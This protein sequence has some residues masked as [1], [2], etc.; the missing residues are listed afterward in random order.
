MPSFVFVV[1][2]ALIPVIPPF[3]IVILSVVECNSSFAKCGTH[4]CSCETTVRPSAEASQPLTVH[5]YEGRNSP[6]AIS[7][8]A[9]S[10]VT[11][12]AVTISLL[13]CSSVNPAP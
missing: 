13:N 2:I 8:F 4:L 1:T 12:F 5:I 10:F 3:G 7:S 11:V 9:L 6:F